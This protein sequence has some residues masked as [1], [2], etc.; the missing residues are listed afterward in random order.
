[1]GIQWFIIVGMMVAS[2]VIAIGEGGLAWLLPA[3][4]WPFC[5]GW[6]GYQV[7]ARRHADHA[8]EHPAGDRAH[9]LRRAALVTAGGLLAI[10]LVTI[11]VY[12]L[13]TAGR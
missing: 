1:M 13:G 5:A 8:T 4:M 3:I 7:V 11:V 12:V 6:I 9:Q 10:E 2:V